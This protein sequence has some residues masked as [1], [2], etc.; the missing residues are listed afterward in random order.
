MAQGILALTFADEDDYELAKV[1]DTWT[2]PNVKRELQEG[3]ERIGA[4]SRSRTARS[5]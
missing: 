3:A 2:L 4:K 1:G 5:S